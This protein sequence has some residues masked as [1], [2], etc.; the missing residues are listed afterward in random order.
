MLF[1]SYNYVTAHDAEKTNF[2]S[3]VT[4]LKQ[5]LID[6]VGSFSGKG[7]TQDSQAQQNMIRNYKELLQY[8]QNSRCEI[9]ISEAELQTKLDSLSLITPAAYKQQAPLYNSFASQVY[10]EFE[11]KCKK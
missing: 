10:E 7:T 5:K 1:M 9:A 8:M 4:I 2:I 6:F 11:A 3:W